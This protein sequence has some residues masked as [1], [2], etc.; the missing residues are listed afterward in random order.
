MCRGWCL[1]VVRA[2]SS[3]EI[4]VLRENPPELRH[5][6]S[7]EERREEVQATYTCQILRTYCKTVWGRGECGGGSERSLG[8]HRVTVGTQRVSDVLLLATDTCQV[9][10]LRT[11]PS[12][13]P[14]RDAKK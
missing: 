13:V 8:W 12:P 6:V 11:H 7:V 9:E 5:R 3:R 2:H 1:V 14:Q 4:M 10:Q